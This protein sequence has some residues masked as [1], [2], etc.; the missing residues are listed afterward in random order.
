MLINT[1]WV[2]IKVHNKQTNG[3]Q[4]FSERN[5]DSIDRFRKNSSSMGLGIEKI[6]FKP[7]RFLREVH[8]GYT[9]HFHCIQ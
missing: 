8:E 5:P 1:E 2:L 4:L 6:V 9:I 7:G 3:H